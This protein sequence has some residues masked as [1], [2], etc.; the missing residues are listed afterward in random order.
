MPLL[1]LFFILLPPEARTRHNGKWP[2][3]KDSPRTHQHL[4]H[5]L[6]VV[7]FPSNHPLSFQ[8]S[9]SWSLTPSL[10]IAVNARQVV[11]S[12]LPIN[13]LCWLSGV[14]NDGICLTLALIGLETWDWDQVM[15]IGHHHYH[16]RH[17]YHIACCIVRSSCG[18]LPSLYL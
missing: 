6:C 14:S 17:L 7:V 16:L 10:F 12:P 18:F 5:R 2:A 13:L 3:K 1:L 11:A 15:R 9:V 4:H 8:F